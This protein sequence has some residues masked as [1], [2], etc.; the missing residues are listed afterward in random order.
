MLCLYTLKA[1][2]HNA[3]Y[4][5]CDDFAQTLSFFRFHLE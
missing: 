4:I 3:V 5:M 2:L 1:S